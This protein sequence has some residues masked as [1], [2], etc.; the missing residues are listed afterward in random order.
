MLVQPLGF[1]AGDRRS[2][3]DQYHAVIDRIDEVV[4]DGPASFWLLDLEEHGLSREPGTL[5]R[6]FCIGDGC[7]AA[8]T[9]A[10]CL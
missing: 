7:H 3:H 1:V 2:Q 10:S 8:G 6:A 5:W 9:L 4:A